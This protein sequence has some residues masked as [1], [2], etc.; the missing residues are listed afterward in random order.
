M[1]KRFSDAYP[2]WL[3][4]VKTLG[5]NPTA[6]VRCPSCGQRDLIVE[7]IPLK[8]AGPESAG[9]EWD[10]PHIDRHLC[11]PGCGAETYL[12]MKKLDS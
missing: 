5:K 8:Y 10:S 6:L 9:L 2:Q 3:E 12:L 1:P 11:C 7:D 4:A